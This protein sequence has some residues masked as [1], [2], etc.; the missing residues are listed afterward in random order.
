MCFHGNQDAKFKKSNSIAQYPMPTYTSMPNLKFLSQIARKLGTKE[1]FW[2]KF[3]KQ[4][5]FHD[6][7]N[8]KSR[9]GNSI[10]QFSMPTYTSMPNL[11]FLSQL[12]R[13]LWTKE[14]FWVKFCKQMCFHGNQKHS[15]VNNFLAI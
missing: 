9:K 10:A 1:C 6:N 4:M 5:C 13:K 15:L 12:A 7:Q 3:C 2:V 11:K 14:C 8:T